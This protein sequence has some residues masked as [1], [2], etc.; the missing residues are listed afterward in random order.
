MTSLE[1]L[2][3]LLAL[4]EGCLAPGLQLTVTCPSVPFVKEQILLVL[5]LFGSTKDHIQ[6]LA[7]NG[8][9]D[10][11]GLKISGWVEYAPDEL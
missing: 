11:E 10:G 5:D 8:A 3:M 6:W 4:R 2:M 1:R 9:K 7:I